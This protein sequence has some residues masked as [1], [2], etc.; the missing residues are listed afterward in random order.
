MLRVVKARFIVLPLAVFFL[1]LSGGAAAAPDCHIESTTQTQSKSVGSHNHSASPHN[2]SHEVA[3]VANLNSQATLLSEGGS[4]NNE[5]CV[6]IGFIVLLLFR[7]LRVTKSI[8]TV[9]QHSRPR[10][11]LP[12]FL[13]KNLSYLNLTHLQLGIIRI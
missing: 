10:Y 4:L 11:L 1:L 9:K 2:H 7:F 8:F 12:Q 13:S 3:S 5:M 6:A